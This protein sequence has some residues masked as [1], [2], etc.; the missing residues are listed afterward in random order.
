[1][2]EKVYADIDDLR[3]E[4]WLRRRN[5]GLLVWQTRDGKEIPVKDMTDQHISNAISC[6]VKIDEFNDIAAEFDS[7][8]K[9]CGNR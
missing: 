4:Q 5:S 9:D 3:L 7:Y 2:E 1:M 8:I 6:I